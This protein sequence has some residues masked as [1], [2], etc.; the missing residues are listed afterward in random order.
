MSRATWGRAWRHKQK[1]QIIEKW[2]LFS[3]VENENDDDNHG[4]TNLER[5]DES[6]QQ[7]ADALWTVQQLDQTHDT[8]ES[9]ERD[10]NWGIFRGLRTKRQKK[11]KSENKTSDKQKNIAD[12]KYRES[13]GLPQLLA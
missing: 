11:T 1:S 3:R 4:V 10:G 2:P 9:E 6:P 7:V 8:E 5:L 13:F 12:L